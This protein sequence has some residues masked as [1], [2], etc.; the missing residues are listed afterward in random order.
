M[1]NNSMSLEAWVVLIFIKINVL[2][3]HDTCHVEGVSIIPSFP[4]AFLLTGFG[5]HQSGR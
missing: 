3:A 2:G 5:C 4:G 1:F